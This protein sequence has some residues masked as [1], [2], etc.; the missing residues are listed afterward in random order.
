MSAKRVSKKAIAIG[1]SAVILGLAGGSLMR[2]YLGGEDFSGEIEAVASCAAKGSVI[3]CAR[4]IVADML[5]THSAAEVMNALSAMPLSGDQCHF[6][7]HLVGQETYQKD[8]T[9]EAALAECSRTCGLACIHG[10][11][12]EAFTEETALDETA[13][14]PAHLTADQLV[15]IGTRLCTSSST[16]HGVGHALVIGATSTADAVTAALPLCARIA[17]GKFAADC[18][19]GVFME[20]SDE[21]ASRSVFATT[22]AA[23]PSLASLRTF[24]DR[25]DIKQ[26]QACFLYLPAMLEYTLGAQGADDSRAAV[27]STT[28][29]ICNGEAN[30]LTR[31]ACIAGFGASYFEHL[32][33]DRTTV[34]DACEQFPTAG[35]REACAF[36]AIGMAA[37]Y[38]ES[39]P[40]LSFCSALSGSSVQKACYEES[41]SRLALFGVPTTT[42]ARSCPN[43]QACLDA[44]A[45]PA[46]PYDALFTR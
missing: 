8:G 25:S 29:S 22:T 1:L 21:L 14:D 7:G 17:S 27:S 5:Q 3:E 15:E 34:V 20:Y 12:G 45:S 19:S 6:I 37:P 2:A 24:C 28:L 33:T 30:P 35:D 39:G 11:I 10:V 38:K 13:V 26:A 36:G 18:Y 23:Y 46:D 43:D 4:P 40:M 31:T 44:A 32:T 9:T 16:C 41:F 42:A